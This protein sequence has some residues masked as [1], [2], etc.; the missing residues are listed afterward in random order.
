MVVERGTRRTTDPGHSPA[1]LFRKPGDD[2]DCGVEEE[3]RT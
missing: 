3:R 2:Q 1:G